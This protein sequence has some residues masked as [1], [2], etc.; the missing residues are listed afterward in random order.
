LVNGCLENL[1][2]CW[3]NWMS[4]LFQESSGDLVRTSCLIWVE[5]LQEFQYTLLG[6]SDV[7]R[8]WDGTSAYMD[9]MSDVSSVVNTDENCWFRIEAFVCSSFF[10]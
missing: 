8:R 6:D 1:G 4:H 3:C 10:V 2:K 9:G 7:R 5:T